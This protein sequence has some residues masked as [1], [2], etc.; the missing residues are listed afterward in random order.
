MSPRSLS[1]IGFATYHKK[2]VPVSTIA[3][4]RS[5]QKDYLPKKSILI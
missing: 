2:G 5:L 3:L 1:F 4:N